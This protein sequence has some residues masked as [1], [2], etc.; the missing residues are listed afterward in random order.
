LAF[1]RGGS[2]SCQNL[3][4]PEQS[5]TLVDFSTNRVQRLETTFL[6]LRTDPNY[7]TGFVNKITM[8]DV[9]ATRCLHM[10]PKVTNIVLQ[11]F[12]ITDI[13]NLHRL[14]TCKIL[15]IFYCRTSFF[16]AIVSQLF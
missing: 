7:S 8:A 16:T 3:D 14:H 9:S 10:L 6:N 15:P 13:C 5:V 1:Y 4:L 12:V 2:G 11:I